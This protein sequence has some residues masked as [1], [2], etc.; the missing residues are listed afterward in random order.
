MRMRRR[1][2]AARRPKTRASECSSVA[3]REFATGW[4]ELWAR[5]IATS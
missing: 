4:Q 1:E 3:A 2:A 5:V